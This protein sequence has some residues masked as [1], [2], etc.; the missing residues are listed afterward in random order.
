MYHDS[1]L[2]VN[3]FATM[4]LVTVQNQ[5]PF[6]TSITTP[7][8]SLGETCD[9]ATLLPFCVILSFIEFIEFYRILGCN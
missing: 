4:I 8:G 2:Q 5:D 3:L 7:R 9:T 1:W 6:E